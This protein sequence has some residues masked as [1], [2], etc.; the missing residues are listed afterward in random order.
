MELW[1]LA[2]STLLAALFAW[3]SIRL[4]YQSWDFHDIS[5]ASDATPLWLP[6]LSMALGTLV[7]LVA[8]IDELV[9]EAKGLRRPHAH[10][11]P[12]FHE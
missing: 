10:D 4:A 7:L 9:L 6:Q 12:A 11:M 8:L 3:Y 1:A 5:T 2:A